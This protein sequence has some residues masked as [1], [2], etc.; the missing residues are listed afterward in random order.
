[1]HHADSEVT[2]SPYLR[3]CT[4]HWPLSEQFS[5]LPA[6]IGTVRQKAGTIY[7][8]RVSVRIFR[9]CRLQKV[10]FINLVE[11]SDKE[12]G[13]EVENPGPEVI[14]GPHVCVLSPH[15]PLLG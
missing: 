3:K 4:F 8:K 15:P 12:R 5:E 13:Q 14:C 11:S 6:A 2:R 9:M 10:F 1:M 7:L